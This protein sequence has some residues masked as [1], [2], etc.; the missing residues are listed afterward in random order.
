MWLK[1]NGYGFAHSNAVATEQIPR[2]VNKN[3]K[4]QLLSPYHLQFLHIHL[5]SPFP[6]ISEYGLT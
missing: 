5:S 2:T 3:T 1:L 4:Y 6:H